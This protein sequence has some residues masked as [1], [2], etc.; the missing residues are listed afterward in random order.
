MPSI[1]KPGTKPIELRGQALQLRKM[2][3][4]ALDFVLDKILVSN[5]AEELKTIRLNIL[6]GETDFS[7]GYFGVLKL[8]AL[9]GMEEIIRREAFGAPPD[10]ELD[11]GELLEIIPAWMEFSDFG[12]LLK[13]LRAAGGVMRNAQAGLRAL[14]GLSETPSQ[15]PPSDAVEDS[16]EP[17]A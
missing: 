14:L 9:P 2:S 15:E 4:S 10:F 12:G 16:T 1:M 3:A 17:K 11:A 13:K 6:L 5:D 7:V 8:A